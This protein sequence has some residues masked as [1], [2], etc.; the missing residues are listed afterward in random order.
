M[1]CVLGY[2]I[3]I[4]GDCSN[5]NSGAF[6]IDILGSAPDYSIQWVNPASGTTALG[7]GVTQYS[8][9]GLSADT[10]TINIIDSCT[11]TNTILPVNIY[12]SS[13][14]CASITAIGN[15]TC[16]LNNGSLSASTTNY[17]GTATFSLYNDDNLFITSGSSFDG[18]ITFDGF[19]TADTYYIVVDDGG[20]CTGKTQTCIVK[21][22]TTVDFGFY[23]VADAGCSVDSGKIFV[24][25]ITGNPPYTYLWN[26]GET[27][28][29]I[30]G[31]TASGYSVTVTDS[32]GCAVT[33]ST[34]VPNVPPIGLGSLVTTNPDCFT[35]NGRVE[36]T[37]T[38][39]T[40]PYYYSGSN[41]TIQITFE[42]TYEFTNLAPGV[43]TIQVTDAGLCTFTT[44][45]SVLPPGGFS[46]TSVSVNP[47]LC[48]NNGGSLNPISIFGGSGNYTYTLEYPDG[49]S[50][51]QATTSQTWQFTNLSAGTY[52]LTIEDGVCTFTSAYTINNLS[53][54]NLTGSTTGTTCGLSNGALELGISGGTPPYTFI[55]NASVFGPTSDSGYT[56]TNLASGNNVVTVTDGTGCTI[57]TS[58]FVD[59][60]RN[61]DFILAGINTTN[62]NDGSI[63]AFITDGEPPF[64]LVWSSN[65]NGQTGLTVN[66]LSAGT[67]TLT[68]TDNLG[69]TKQKSVI[70]EGTNLITS[71][72]T[73]SICDTNFTNSGIQIKKGPREMLNEGFYDLTIDDVNCVLNS[74]VFQVKITLGSTIASKNF[75]TGTTLND[76]PSDNLWYDTIEQIL[77][78]ESGIGNVIIDPENNIIKILS[79]CDPNVTLSD[80]QVLIDMVIFYN[81]SCVACD[82]P[83]SPTPTP[84]VTRTPNVTPTPTVTP[85]LT[86]TKTPSP[87]PTATPTVT[88]TMFAS[89][90]PT[91]TPT[92][93]QFAS[94][95]P[96][97]TPTVTPTITPTTTPTVTPTRT[98]TPSPLYRAHTVIWNSSYCVGSVCDVTGSTITVYTT[99]GVTSLTNGVTIYIND[100]LTSIFP[101]GGFLKQGGVNQVFNIDGNGVLGLECSPIGGGC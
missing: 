9:S 11:P 28:S 80:K 2:N 69:C 98:P 1:S 62:G 37:V 67:Y 8:I 85:G 4:T 74:A 12:I 26:N 59:P 100:T 47:T 55:A 57:T 54:M 49:S 87:T 65:V 10:Y 42:P 39:G 101:W 27:T 41:G 52:N 71:Y 35:S 21:S 97:T 48:G 96:T 46:I 93:T 19:L 79:N 58:Y 61:V 73:Y 53:T 75:Y 43:F 66:N 23:V 60:S 18:T 83:P 5:T 72:Q 64:T 78:T 68:V 7:A 56:F 44:T 63:T 24:T 86:P 22:S 32:T 82:V 31:L 90:T 38:G 15:T 94:P 30:T 51:S 17:Y 40:A 13:G 16:G 36:I 20:G 50:V 33:K 77:E 92:P 45:T 88:P 3:S 76:Y 29:S 70:I 6:T 91:T 99:Y 25:G 95:T 84:T 34:S 14:T 81:I 89:P